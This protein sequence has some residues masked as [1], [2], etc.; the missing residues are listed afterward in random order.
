MWPFITGSGHKEFTLQVYFRPDEN[1]FPNPRTMI[2]LGED[3][4]GPPT[5]DF[6][7]IE[8]E[9]PIIPPGYAEAG[10][11]YDHVLFNNARIY[12]GQYNLVSIVASGSNIADAYLRINKQVENY[13]TTSGSWDIPSSAKHWLGAGDQTYL[14]QYHPEDA[15]MFYAV[16]NK[17]L[18]SAQIEQNYDYFVSKSLQTI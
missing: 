18:S 8:Y 17:A 1:P 4:P 16:Y 9:R 11:A 10:F 6:I 2:W 14:N 15:Y 12:G 3:N 7:S 13:C 5:A